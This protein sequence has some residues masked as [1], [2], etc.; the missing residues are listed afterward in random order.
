MICGQA[1]QAIC[2][3]KGICRVPEYTNFKA[4]QHCTTRTKELRKGIYDQIWS[5]KE[6]EISL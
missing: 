4:S 6:N 2:N 3:Y 5:K 1:K